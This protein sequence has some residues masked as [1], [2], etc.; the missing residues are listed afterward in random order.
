MGS[1]ITWFSTYKCVER[2]VRP[3]S[4]GVGIS[5]AN[6]LGQHHISGHKGQNSIR[7]HKGRNPSGTRCRG[8]LALESQC[9]GFLGLGISMSW[10]FILWK[11][12]LESRCRGLFVSVSRCR[13][14][15]VLGSRCRG[16]LAL[17]SRCRSFLVLGSRCRGMC[18]SAASFSFSLW[19]Q[20]KNT[21]N[22]FNYIVEEYFSYPN[23]CNTY[24]H[25]VCITRLE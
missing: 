4:A 5:A 17:E 20:K 24:Q 15:L 19:K 3:V 18:V 1:S 11:N 10:L 12:A 23:L 2:P 6:F 22:Y 13:G 7:G 14:F 25:N 8:F 16:F 21:Q 9:R